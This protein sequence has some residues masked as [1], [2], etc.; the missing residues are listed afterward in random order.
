MKVID[1]N[2]ILS[3]WSI[4]IQIFIEIPLFI[5]FLIGWITTK[6][7]VMLI[8][9]IAWILNLSALGF[10]LYAAKIIVHN[11]ST[12]FDLIT[13]G[14]YGVFKISFAF[15]LLF[16][17][18]Q[19][20]KKNRNVKFPYLYYLPIFIIMLILFFRMKAVEIQFWVYGIVSVSFFIGCFISLKYIKGKD[21]I[22][23]GAGFFIN[24]STFFHHFL[25]LS[26]WFKR[27]VVPVYMSRISFY[28]AISEFILALSFFLA[29]IINTIEELQHINSK[30]VENQ[31]T[32]RSLVDFDPLTGLKNRRVMRK[33]IEEVKN[34]KG[35]IAFMDIDN[36]KRIND[37]YGHTFGDR[38]L[39]GVA[40]GLKN[41]FRVSD[42]L[43]RYGG[44]EFLVIVS[45]L[46]TQ[47]VW[48]RLDLVNEKLKKI[49][50]GVELSLSF[51]ISEFDVNSSFEK[52]LNEA[53]DRMYNKKNNIKTNK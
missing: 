19:Y 7:R 44:D 48:N 28:D 43:F 47:E 25:I 38:C 6:K 26:P 22:I 4:F 11:I 46:T 36:F 24:A 9:T 8:W 52:V 27:M 20:S 5:I 12:P 21:G 16:S 15:L 45:N 51:G 34:K 35:V 33:V 31:E 13:Y 50:N 41:V 37:K 10:V 30:L 17:A 23:M 18:Y 53:D 32:L 39:I 14:A 29:I 2:A 42:G 49:I 3:S 1:I 40:R